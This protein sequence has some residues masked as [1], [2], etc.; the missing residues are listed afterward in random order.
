MNIGLLGFKSTIKRK[1]ANKKKGQKQIKKN[2]N[3]KSP[4]PRT[5]EKGKSCMSSM[6]PERWC[7]QL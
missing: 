6:C 1:K 5:F 7:D 2:P 3:P 4:N